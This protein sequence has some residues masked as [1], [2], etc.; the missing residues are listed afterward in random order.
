MRRLNLDSLSFEDLLA[1]RDSV[2]RLISKKATAA[3]KE[4]QA[5]LQAIESAAGEINGADGRGRH[6]LKGRKLAPKYR[7][8][9][10]RSETWAGRGVM[11]LWLR[12]QLKRGKKLDDFAVKR[13][14]AA[15]T[16]R[17]AKQSRKKG[18]Q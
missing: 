10:N 16:T 15:R 12:D 1:V 3:K 7:N 5:K 2:V 13:A 4:L 11:P 8:P 9:Q 18:A 14:A 17:R 6:F